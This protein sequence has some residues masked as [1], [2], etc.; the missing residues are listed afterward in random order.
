MTQFVHYP[1]YDGP[2]PDPAFSAPPPP[3]PRPPRRSPFD[4]LLADPRR[5]LLLLGAVA[6]LLVLAIVGLWYGD[7]TNRARRELAGANERIVEKQREVADARRRLAEKVAE[8][9]AARA[10]ADVQATRYRGIVERATRPAQLDTAALDTTALG[11]EV[12]P[13][14]RADSAVV[15]PRP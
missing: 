15:V 7:P 9:R 6:A 14:D 2:E 3:P 4:G 12:V 5:R 13:G 11:G 10:E 8:L 1:E